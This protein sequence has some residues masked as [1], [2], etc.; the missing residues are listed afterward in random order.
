MEGT[1]TGSIL[2]HTGFNTVFTYVSWAPTGAVC[3]NVIITIKNPESGFNASARIASI[4][5][6]W[7]VMEIQAPQFRG[8]GRR[9]AN[10]L[11]MMMTE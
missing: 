2:V 6:A 5:S 7:I 4:P 10:P 3:S 9:A 1:C 8:A 11:L